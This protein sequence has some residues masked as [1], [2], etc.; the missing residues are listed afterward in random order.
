VPAFGFAFYVLDYEI[1][2]ADADDQV[3]EIKISVADHQ[4]AAETL[5]G[6]YVTGEKINVGNTVEDGYEYESDK[7]AALIFTR[8]KIPAFRSQ[9]YNQYGDAYQISD[10]HGL[11]INSAIHKSHL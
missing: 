9:D 6:N 5:S 1:D 8:R 3:I 7:D 10:I 4:D 2:D 11:Q